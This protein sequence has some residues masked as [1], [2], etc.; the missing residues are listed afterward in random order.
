M[1]QL[2]REGRRPSFAVKFQFIVQF[3][4]MGRTKGPLV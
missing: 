2:C 1:T 3:K 4:M